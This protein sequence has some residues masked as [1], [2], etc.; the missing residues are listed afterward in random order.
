MPS[1]IIPIK[2]HFPENWRDLPA[3]V[4]QTIADKIANPPLLLK[5]FDEDEF[6][7]ALRQNGWKLHRR[8]YKGRQ[9]IYLTKDE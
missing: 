2:E 3:H 1:Y 4:R 9:R 8:K 5:E 7:S 6:I